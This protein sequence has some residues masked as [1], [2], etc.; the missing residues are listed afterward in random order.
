MIDLE[1]RLVSRLSGAAFIKWSLVAGLVGIGP[2]L[3]YTLLGPAD[4]NPIGLGLLAVVTAPLVLAG[5]LVGII[6]LMVELLRGR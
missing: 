4:G 2:L 1:E 6:K 3:L 5:L